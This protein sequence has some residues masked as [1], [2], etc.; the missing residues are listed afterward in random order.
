[1]LELIGFV[2]QAT[3][4]ALVLYN[5]V[6]SLWGW[7]NPA[8]APTRGDDRRLRVVIPA[9]NEARVLAG[10][11]TDLKASDFPGHLVEVWVIDDRST[12][13]TGALAA[14]MGVA[15]AARTDGDGGKGQALAWY[16]DNHPLSPDETLVVF[17]A[18][19]RIP[20]NTLS[21]MADEI[22]AGHQVV[23]C[24][25]DVTN[26]EGSWMAEA[27]ALSYWA[28]NRMV[29][30]AR[31]NLGWS[32]DLGGTA[33]GITAGALEQAGGFADSLTEDQDLGVRLLLAGHKVEWLHDVRVQDEK[34]ETLGVAVRQRARWMA[35]KRATR[36]RHLGA[37]LRQG[38]LACFDMAIRLLQPGRS[39][40]AL[41][42]VVMI[43]VA[44]FTS[45]TWV[46][47]WQLWAT[48]AVV[49]VMLPIPFLFRDG[50]ET[51]HIVRYPLLAILAAL[52]LPIRLV[53]S[54]VSGWYHTPHTGVTSDDV[55][56][57]DL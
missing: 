47:P 38:S 54:R 41:L 30:L 7:P 5:T 12:D 44:A 48:L 56:D 9:H 40:M 46:F 37:L 53:S 35:G 17:D 49:Q 15:V 18:D 33:M 39:F 45:W 11:L 29:Q 42:T 32:A 4:I 55:P 31:S 27:S 10:V 24:Y 36:R 13:D 3:L 26:P 57:Q 14:S 16:L 34:P 6:T 22:A 50:V 20:S 8:P 1:M 21:R 23:Q 52:W 28:G 2:P 25:L 51:R 19:N 43:A